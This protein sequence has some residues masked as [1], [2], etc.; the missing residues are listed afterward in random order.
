MLGPRLGLAGD[1]QGGEHDGQVSPDAV[2]EAVK[3]GP[4]GQIGFG[5]PEGNARLG[6]G[7]GRQPRPPGRPS[8]RGPE[9]P[10]A[11]TIQAE[12]VVDVG[13]DLPQDQR[14]C[15]LDH[16]RRPRSARAGVVEIQSQ[17]P[18]MAALPGD[19]QQQRVRR[20]CEL[21][22]CARCSA[23]AGPLV[24]DLDHGR[25]RGGLHPPHEHAHPARLPTPPA[26]LVTTSE[27]IRR[28]T[29]RSAT[30][31]FTRSPDR[32]NSGQGHHAARG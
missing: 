22:R 29:H 6:R 4:G 28:R 3:H 5:H 31:A 27:P 30:S 23:R 10:I 7:R 25:T 17:L 18:G 11:E 8:Q 32:Y 9:H 13:Q 15:A 2:F 21:S 20:R 26:V 14:G 24:R 12:V 16:R 19:L 1:G